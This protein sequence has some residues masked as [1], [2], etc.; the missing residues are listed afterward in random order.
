[1]M[2]ERALEYVEDLLGFWKADQMP[3]DEYHRLPGASPSQLAQFWRVT[4]AEA[5]CRMET[6]EENSPFLLMG[7]LGHQMVL[8]PNRELPR[9]ALH[10]LKYPGKDGKELDWHMGAAVCKQWVKAQEKAGFITMPRKAKK[11]CP[12]WDELLLMVKSISTHP[13]VRPWLEDTQSI[14]ESSVIGSWVSPFRIMMRSRVDLAPG[15]EPF[16]ADC[17]F[18][19]DPSPE[20]F[21]YHIADRGYHIQAALTLDLWN[22]WRPKDQRTGWRLIAVGQKAPHLTVVHELDEEFIEA[23]RKAYQKLIHRF[24]FCYRTGIWAGHAPIAHVASM[25]KKWKRIEEEEE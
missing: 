5:K 15:G 23:G 2:N 1:M 9:I 8:E 21:P 6:L 24:E 3:A 7:S 19:R 12:G 18:T 14:F 25:P 10:P 13:M 22:A 4:D 20:G 11:G 16:L 17:K